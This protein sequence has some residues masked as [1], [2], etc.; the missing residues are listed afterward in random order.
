[1]WEQSLEPELG[2]HCRG[3]EETNETKEEDAGCG[4]TPDAPRIHLIFASGLRRSFAAERE[5]CSTGVVD[6]AWNA[7]WKYKQVRLCDCNQILPPHY[8]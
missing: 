3:K 2:H 1:M 7:G 8:M 5:M 4:E 6:P